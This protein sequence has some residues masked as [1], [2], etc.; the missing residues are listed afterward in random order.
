MP[1]TGPVQ[2]NLIQPNPSDFTLRDMR[3]FHDFM[4]TS[5]PHLPLESD[6]AWLNDIP[7]L[8]QQHEFLMHGILALGAAHLHARTNLELTESVHRHRT[9]AMRGLN[10]L[11]NA[12]ESE[13]KNGDPG[14][15]LTALLAT[16]Y[17]LAFTSSYM[18]DALS[19]FLV[20]IRACA[21][22]TYQIITNG[23]PSP[24]LPWGDRSATSQPHLEVMRRRLRNAPALP[25]DDVREALSSLRKVEQECTLLPFQQ[26]MLHT[27]IACL[28]TIATPY[29]GK[30]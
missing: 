20:L 14:S 22:I 6:E 21:S 9:I 24:L 26:N 4:T 8:A 1:I 11:A 19:T 16:S 7:V 5:W 3:L 15:R 12:S 23:H 30:C 29:E 18:G 17:L 10:D 2:V 27:M 13:W 25:E 28:E